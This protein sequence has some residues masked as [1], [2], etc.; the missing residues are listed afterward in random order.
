MEKRKRRKNQ[1]YHFRE[2]RALTLTWTLRMKVYLKLSKLLTYLKNQELIN[3]LWEFNKAIKLFKTYFQSLIKIQISSECN[4]NCPA[5]IV[6]LIQKSQT[7]STS[8]SKRK[9][10]KEKNSKMSNLTMT[11]NWRRFKDIYSNLN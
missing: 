8:L 1:L 10:L 5:D 4:L 7:Y 9:R 6:V 2:A 3:K 11:S